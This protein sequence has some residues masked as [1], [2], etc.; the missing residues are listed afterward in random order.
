[1][2]D[3]YFLPLWLQVYYNTEIDIYLRSLLR[4]TCKAFK[5]NLFIKDYY[6]CYRIFVF[7]WY[8]INKNYE[9]IADDSINGNILYNYNYNRYES[10]IQFM[11]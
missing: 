2:D 7:S 9:L 4:M 1:M 11:Y 10:C 5:K 3:Y 6:D 8:N